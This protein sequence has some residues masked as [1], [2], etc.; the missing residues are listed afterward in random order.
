MGN[1]EHVTSDTFQDEV[2][3]S[4]VPVLVDFY[5]TWC[6]PCRMLAPVI[7]DLA[8]KY[9]GKAKVL[10]VNVSEEPGLAQKYGVAAVPTLLFFNNGELVDTVV[11]LTGAEELEQKLDSLIGSSVS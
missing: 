8:E 9:A 6:G 1:A 2:I 10:K 5:S 11:G 7:E 3:S 4:S